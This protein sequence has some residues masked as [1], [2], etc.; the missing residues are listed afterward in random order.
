MIYIIPS[1]DTANQMISQFDKLKTHGENFN[2][3][4]LVCF[5]LLFKTIFNIIRNYVCF[6]KPIPSNFGQIW[7]GLSTSNRA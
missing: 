3:F 1:Q 6:T 2:S 4:Y 7:P 5:N